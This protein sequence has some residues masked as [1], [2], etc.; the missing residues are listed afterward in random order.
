MVRLA[1]PFPSTAKLTS[2]ETALAMQFYHMAR[3]LLLI[4]KPHETTAGRSTIAERLRSYRDIESEI[5]HHSCEIVGIALS[6]PEDSVRIHQLQPLFVAGQ[7]FTK[8]TERRIVL[9]LL[10]DIERD[11]GFATEYRIK[12]LLKQWECEEQSMSTL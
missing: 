4:N 2:I 6:Q 11:L 12:Q 9:D 7:C 5:R 1:K 3:I 8:A 10:R